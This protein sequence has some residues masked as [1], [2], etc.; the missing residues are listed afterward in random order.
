MPCHPVRYLKVTALIG[1][2]VALLI[3][4]PYQEGAFVNLDEGLAHATQQSFDHGLHPGVQYPLFLFFAFAIAWTTIDI[5]RNTLKAVVAAGAL[6][7]IISM[8]FV[9]RL[10]NVFFSPFPSFVA[11]VASFAAGIVYSRS[12]GGSRK[13]VMRQ[14]LGERVSTKT[15]YALLNSSAPLNLER[16]TPRH[17]HPRL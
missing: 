15:F 4:I 9:L 6:L 10:L 5:P 7:Q 2:F 12:E 13:R 16:R 11:V 8:V 1:F 17:Q 3:A 14:I